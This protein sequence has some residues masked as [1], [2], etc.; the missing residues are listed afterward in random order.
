MLDKEKVLSGLHKEYTFYTREAI[1][2]NSNTLRN[3]YARY[4]SVILEIINSLESGDFDLQPENKGT[5]VWYKKESN[6][7]TEI[8]C[9]SNYE[10]NHWEFCPFCGKPIERRGE[11]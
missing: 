7:S 5:C 10:K 2:T 11:K 8:A 6:A 3:N 9:L 1:D 4:S